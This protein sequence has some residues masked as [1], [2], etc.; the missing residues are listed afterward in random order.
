LRAK[1]HHLAKELKEKGY[2]SDKTKALNSSG[3]NSSAI[4]VTRG[5]TYLDKVLEEVHKASSTSHNSG[6]STGT[7]HGK[8]HVYA[9][10]SSNDQN[11]LL[12]IL[13]TYVEN[14]MEYCAGENINPVHVFQYVHGKLP[15]NS[16]SGWQSFC[17]LRRLLRA[18]GKVTQA[19]KCWA[20]I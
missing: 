1:R 12:N 9:P 13:G 10:M 14:V 8:A 4:C 18:L 15:L 16:L 7:V 19:L 11:N 5:A 2:S 3:S 17:Q 6:K 20:F